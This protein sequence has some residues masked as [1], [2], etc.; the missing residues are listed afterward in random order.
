MEILIFMENYMNKND[1]I[2][3]YEPL[4]GKWRVKEIIGEGSTGKVY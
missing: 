4:W 1:K 2:F 3:E